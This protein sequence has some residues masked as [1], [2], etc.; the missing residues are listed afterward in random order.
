M[1]VFSAARVCATIAADQKGVVSREQLL[2]PGLT[3]AMITRLIREG[4]LH[5]LHRGV[6]A[7]GHV[8]LPRFGKEQAALLACGEGAVI[9]GRSALY[10]WGINDMGPAEVE[11]TVAGRHRRK[12]RGIRLHRVATLDRGDVRTRHGLSV[13]FPA[14]ALIEFAAVASFDE[15]GDAVAEARQRGLIRDGELEAAANAAGRRRG[16]AQTR[17]FLLDE[18]EPA[19]TRSRGERRLRKLV[20]DAR[21]PQPKANV[22]VAQYEVDF[23]WPEQRV[24]LELDSYGFHGHRR[25]FERDHRKTMVLEDAGF[26]VIRVTR[27]QLLEE[28]YWVVAHIARALD[29]HGRAAA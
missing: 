2:S 3:S 7:V 8:A 29:R 4:F 24:V 23:L 28:P 20:R 9:S 14:R 18:G 6:Y 5:P 12:Q 11:V 15:L 27:R 26:H 19:M 1:H 22:R 10:L 21:L 16:A 17:A 25:A 13:V